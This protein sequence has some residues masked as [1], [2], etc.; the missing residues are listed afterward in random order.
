MKKLFAFLALSCGAF[1]HAAEVTEY[2]TVDN[3]QMDANNAIYFASN[4]GWGAKGC[5][6]ARYIFILRAEDRLV[7]HMLSLVLS[8]QATGRTIRAQGNCTDSR[9]FRV[10]YLYQGEK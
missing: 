1:A 3:V 10:T 7:D 8:S 9:H 5:P 4:Q 6:N 2:R